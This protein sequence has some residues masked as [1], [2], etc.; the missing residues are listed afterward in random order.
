M[1]KRVWIFQYKKEVSQKGA[2]DASWYVGWYDLAGKRH[3][4]S[5]GAGSRGKN[6]AEKRL[7][8]V[9]SELDTGV[10]QPTSKKSWLDFQQEYDDR[11]LSGLAPKTRDAA[12]DSL[13]HFKRIANRRLRHRVDALAFQPGFYCV[14]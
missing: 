6:L 7:R 11:I 2:D 1:N 5:C 4:E 12:I 9:Q 14:E 3:S 8:R 13:D 10:H